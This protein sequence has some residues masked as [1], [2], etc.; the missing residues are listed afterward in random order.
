[1]ATLAIRPSVA[2]Y[3]A[4]WISTFKNNYSYRFVFLP[5]TIGSIYYISKYKDYLKNNI[6]AGF[7]LTCIG[8]ER[9]YSFLPSKYGNTLFNK[10]SLKILKKKIKKFKIYSCLERG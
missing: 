3:L 7:N 8:D 6:L 9:K 10:I 4:K 2:I 1:M 5:E